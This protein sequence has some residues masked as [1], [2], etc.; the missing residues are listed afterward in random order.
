LPLTFPGGIL[1]IYCSHA[2]A[3][4]S[5]FAGGSLPQCLKGSDLTFYSVLKSFGL[6]V[7]IHPVLQVNRDYSDDSSREE[8]ADE[9]DF[10]GDRLEPIEIFHNCGYDSGDEYSVGTHQTTYARVEL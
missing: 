5:S 10:I 6:D 2:Y 3:H 1:G 8:E 4:T 7:K 9:G